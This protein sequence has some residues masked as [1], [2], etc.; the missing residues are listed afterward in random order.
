MIGCIESSF[1]FLVWPL[2]PTCFRCRWLLVQLIT[3]S[4]T[5]TLGTTPLDERSARFRYLCLTKYNIH[6]RQTSV[7]PGGIRTRNPSKR[8]TADRRLGPHRSQ[9]RS[10]RV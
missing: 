4:D 1:F 6:K 8:A 2:P 7:P 5:C 3:L 10:H 9:D